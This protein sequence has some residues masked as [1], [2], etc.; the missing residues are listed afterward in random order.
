MKK[1]EFL[2]FFSCLLC[3]CSSSDELKKLDRILDNAPVYERSFHRQIDS[4]KTCFSEA[5]NDSARFR[6]AWE[7][8][9]RYKVYNIDTCLQY[10]RLMED[11]AR[12]EKETLIAR[13]ALVY[14][15]VCMG[16]DQEA[17]DI[18]HS[19]PTDF[20]FDEDTRIY[21]EGGVHLFWTMAELHPEIKDSCWKIRQKIR[22]ELLQ[23]DS[24]SY[25]GKTYLIHEKN[26]EK[27]YDELEDIARSILALDDLP[28]RYRAITED[29][30]GL[31]MRKTNRKDEAIELFTQAAII[32]LTTATKEYNSLYHLAR[33]LHEK[34]DNER[35]CR[36]MIR[37]VN[38]AIFCN[39]YSHYKRSALAAPM[40]HRAFLQESARNKRHM[41]ELTILL[42]LLL[43]VA[44]L[45][46]VA[47]HIYAGR[48]RVAAEKIRVTNEKLKI[49]NVQLK[50]GNAIR[51]NVL[52][53]YMEKSAYYIKMVDEVK[54]TMRR[55]YR[56]EGQDA[57][58]KMLRSPA[59][60]DTEFKN[61]FREFDEGILR[62]FPHFI[63][64]VNRLTT[65]EHAF[66]LD[67]NGSFSTE[68]RVLALIRLGITDSSQI[69]NALNI[70]IGTTYV[71]RYRMRHSAVCPPEEF[72]NRIREIGLYD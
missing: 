72:E 41:S 39:Y 9:D 40:I 27:K 5:E 2:L 60:S 23:H 29:N 64:E 36:Y 11:N 63:E 56:K 65:P 52:S 13:S 33:L 43:A 31:L 28:L 49:A 68:L 48:E 42:A 58:L 51:D 59:Y 57:L 62:M 34:G 21:Y 16:K 6:I 14:A 69:A 32:D 8:S 45:L 37:T 66:S 61:Y 53:Q 3:A 35:A 18:F 24:T 50:D 10:V 26:T 22:L 54:S 55:T 44:T 38:D 15:L 19:I 4:L 20:P 71:Y 47:R 12:S 67:K 30:L 46:L 70:S 25:F 17:L 1:F 7:I